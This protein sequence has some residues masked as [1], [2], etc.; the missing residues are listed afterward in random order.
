MP[1]PSAPNFYPSAPSAYPSNPDLIYKTGTDAATGADSATVNVTWQL[2]EQGSGAEQISG[3]FGSGSVGSLSVNETGSFS[4]NV[5]VSR[6]APVL[7]PPPGPRIPQTPVADTRLLVA[8]TRTGRIH[9]ELPY[10]QQMSWSQQINQ[11]GQLSAYIPVEDSLESLSQQGVTDPAKLLWGIVTGPYR[12]S[13]LVCYGNSVLWGGPLLPTNSYSVGQFSSTGGS[14]QQPTL[15][16]AAAELSQMFTK[17]Y[18]TNPAGIGTMSD[19]SRDVNFYQTNQRALMH[20]LVSFATSK[21]VGYELPIVCSDPPDPTGT[22]NYNYL[23]YDLVDVAKALQTQAAG[24]DGPDFRLD[25]YLHD[26]PDAEY[27]AYD[28]RIGDPYLDYGSSW[29]FDDTTTY[30]DPSG[31][32]VGMASTL[33]VPGSGQDRAKLIGSAGDP[34]YIGLGFPALE[35]TDGSLNSETDQSMLDLYASAA[36]AAQHSPTLTW[37][38][39]SPS[40]GHP[41]A[42]QYRLGDLANVD[43]RAHLLIDHGLYQSRIIGIAGD[44]TQWIT[45]TLSL[46]E[47]AGTTG[48]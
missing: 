29:T 40:D 38:V 42:G 8:D 28:L 19:P 1:H 35:D 24:A 47:D 2:T 39:S 48:G 33:F 15:Q 44:Y 9:F 11:V 13:I 46:D 5:D 18:L 21:G 26:G 12:Y 23:S 45:L 10:G 31:D 14:E 43:V 7:F 4:D 22:T 3:S 32:A 17:R 41:Q 37:K 16:I 34:S 36:V 25:P 30:I 6:T 27:V 20:D